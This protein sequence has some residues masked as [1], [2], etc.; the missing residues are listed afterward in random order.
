MEPRVQSENDFSRPYEGTSH[1]S[2]DANIVARGR[3]EPAFSDSNYLCPDIRISF[4][5]DDGVEEV[6]KLHEASKP[7]YSQQ[8]HSF[9]NFRLPRTSITD[10][11]NGENI[12]VTMNPN[13][14]FLFIE[15]PPARRLSHNV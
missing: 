13:S 15:Q 14:D 11:F 10:Q 6:P 12:G 4:D 8:R 7:C 3:S 1:F 9:S 5:N 2:L